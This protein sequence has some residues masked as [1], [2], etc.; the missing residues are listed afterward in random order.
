MDLFIWINGPWSYRWRDVSTSVSLPQFSWA[1]STQL[2]LPGDDEPEPFAAWN[3]LGVTPL[4]SAAG[5]GHIEPSSQAAFRSSLCSSACCLNSLTLSSFLNLSCSRAMEEEESW[6]TDGSL[7]PINASWCL[8]LFSDADG[9][10]CVLPTI[11]YLVWV[12]IRRCQLFIAGG[13]SLLIFIAEWCKSGRII[14]GDAQSKE[15]RFLGPSSM[16]FG[17]RGGDEEVNSSPSMHG[18]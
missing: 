4:K 6:N 12:V 13:V 18:V 11:C 15:E 17:C 3:P 9:N 1:P 5:W 10:C 16:E 2:L 14:E 7:L 8:S